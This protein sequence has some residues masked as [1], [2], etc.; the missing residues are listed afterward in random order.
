ML[1]KKIVDIVIISYSK[2]DYCKSITE[3]CITSLLSSEDNSEEI[4]NIIIVESEPSVKWENFSKCIKT[5]NAPLPYGYNKFLNFGRKK[6][7][8]EW[9]AL[10]NNDLEF[11]K[12]WFSEMLIAEK[13]FPNVLSFSPICPKTQ[14]KY[15]IYP[16]TG[17]YEGYNIRMQ[18]S[19]WCIVQKRKIYE[20]IGDLD[21]R[22]H[23][24]FCDNDYA[25][26]L[27]IKKIPH[28][29]V[30]SS[31]VEHHEN[32]IG[33]ITERVVKDDKE[34]KRLTIDSQFIFLEKWKNYF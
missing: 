23:H 34:M 10:C 15:N 26:T 29:L 21:E 4:F 17:Y 19:G 1:N 13:K 18:I 6:G 33:K 30:S 9:V 20:I 28:I 12:N 2:D 5:Y 31:I 24:W 7:N 27:M 8:S 25:M 11:K 32:N 3:N 22:F 14:P 16:N